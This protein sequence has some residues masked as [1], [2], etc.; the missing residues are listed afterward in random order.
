VRLDFVAGLGKQ[1]TGTYNLAVTVPGQP[2]VRFERLPVGSPGWKRLRW[3]GFI[4]LAREKTA[5]YLDQVKLE[6]K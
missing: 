5:I 4:S 3:L 6:R 2:P 1:A